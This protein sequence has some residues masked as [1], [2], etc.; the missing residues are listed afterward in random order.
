MKWNDILNVATLT[1]WQEMLESTHTY[2]VYISLL[3][4][5]GQGFLSVRSL[6]KIYTQ[7]LYAEENKIMFEL[8]NIVLLSQQCLLIRTRG[9]Q[10]KLSCETDFQFHHYEHLYYISADDYNQLTSLSALIWLVCSPLVHGKLISGLY[11]QYCS[12]EQ[13]K[14][15]IYPNQI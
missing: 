6:H 15:V 4:R 14:T 2:N 13:P 1:C 7:R 5:C 12:K 11:F 10:K 8:Y 3:M 9:Q